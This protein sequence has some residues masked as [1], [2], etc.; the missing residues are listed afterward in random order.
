MQGPHT[1]AHAHLRRGARREVDGDFV[2]LALELCQHSLQDLVEGP[3]RPAH[4]P[5]ACPAHAAHAHA[6]AVSVAGGGPG[7]GDDWAGGAAGRDPMA[8]GGGPW[9]GA[10]MG[11]GGAGAGRALEA[12]AGRRLMEDVAAG[13]AF[14]H[15]LGIVHRDI[16]PANILLTAQARAGRAGM[17]EGRL[18]TGGGRGEGEGAGRKKMGRVA[19][20]MRKAEE[21]GGWGSCETV[22]PA[23]PPH[24]P[25]RART[26]E[27]GAY[28]DA[29]CTRML[30][31]A[32]MLMLYVACLCILMLYVACL[33][34]LML[35]VA[36]L[37]MLMLYVY[38]C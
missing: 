18:G 29:G 11:G 35:Y 5:A 6:P 22:A 31:V 33:C 32:C 24:H 27:G 16:K 17:G 12:E 37:C 13:L 38:V 10:G 14:L 21:E 9:A 15:A 20:K 4:A 30:Y 19:G 8:A 28:T 26:H 25:Q 36:C 34:I 2:Y 7:W 1:H 3:P 23:P